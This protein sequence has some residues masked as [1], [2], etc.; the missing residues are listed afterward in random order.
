M[1]GQEIL[2]FDE[3]EM[4]DR[5]FEYRFN[6]NNDDFYRQL[7]GNTF[8]VLRRFNCPNASNYDEC[9]NAMFSSLANGDFPVVYPETIDIH[10]FDG[11]SMVATRTVWVQQGSTEDIPIVGSFGRRLVRADESLVRR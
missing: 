7:D 2:W 9:Q 11:N 8:S 4:M 6:T 10:S 5:S 1:L 3:N